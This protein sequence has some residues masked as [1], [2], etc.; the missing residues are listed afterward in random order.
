MTFFRKVWWT[1]KWVLRRC[2][3]G[4]VEDLCQISDGSWIK[5]ELYAVSWIIIMPDA[6]ILRFD[7]ENKSP[8]YWA[9]FVGYIFIYINIVWLSLR[10]P[11]IFTRQ[12]PFQLIYLPPF[13][14]SWIGRRLQN[15]NLH[16]FWLVIDTQQ[17]SWKWHRG[18]IRRQQ[19]EFTGIC[20]TSKNTRGSTVSVSNVARFGMKV[21]ISCKFS[22]I[23][24]IFR[25]S[26]FVSTWNHRN[27][28]GKSQSR[29]WVSL[30]SFLDFSVQIN[31]FFTEYI[32]RVHPT[33]WRQNKSPSQNHL[34]E[35]QPA[36]VEKV[37][38]H[39]KEPIMPLPHGRHPA[40]K[41]HLADMVGL[42]VTFWCLDIWKQFKQKFCFVSQA[43]GIPS[44]HKDG[45]LPKFCKSF[46]TLV[47][48]TK[49]QSSCDV[50][51]LCLGTGGALAS[52]A[53]GTQPS[54][55]RKW[56]LCNLQYM[57]ICCVF[58]KDIYSVYLCV[59]TLLYISVT[60]TS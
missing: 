35:H 37:F 9:V 11:N 46:A 18:G 22:W 33:N 58:F 34:P 23:D 60:T 16:R 54:V 49:T 24:D 38:F 51:Q 3:P 4:K 44:Y 56:R 57:E 52:A 14:S 7:V 25:W 26:V 5:Q 36:T 10:S 47:L 59:H 45:F 53:G 40:K 55:W 30:T 15:L 8:D 27:E 43:S 32:F 12:T 48:F 2:D 21:A 41:K 20:D 31:V 42:A 50:A 6:Y 1:F 39:P 19:L 29:I 28:N 17:V 13:L